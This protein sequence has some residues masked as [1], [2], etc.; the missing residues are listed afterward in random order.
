MFEDI[1]GKKEKKTTY[2]VKDCQTCLNYAEGVD[3][4]GNLKTI[5]IC[6]LHGTQFTSGEVVSE[7]PDWQK[8]WPPKNV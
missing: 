4:P 2:I 7:C 8:G 1:L 5:D 6:R 3:L